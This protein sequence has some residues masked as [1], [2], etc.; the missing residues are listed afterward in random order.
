MGMSRRHHGHPWPHSFLSCSCGPGQVSHGRRLD[1]LQDDCS[2][3]LWIYSWEWPRCICHFVYA[4]CP[5]PS[6]PLSSR[7][8]ENA[9]SDCPHS[10]DTR[11]VPPGC[12]RVSPGVR[13][14][15]RAAARVAHP[16]QLSQDCD[17]F[18]TGGPAS[19]GS[20]WSPVAEMV[21]PS[22]PS[23]RVR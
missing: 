8:K 9:P 11:D 15:L 20:L 14:C 3:K 16:S 1:S 21:G 17:G 4:L 19:L 23:H 18:S 2:E 12:Q 5:L 7:A 6:V 22:A 10:L 13:E